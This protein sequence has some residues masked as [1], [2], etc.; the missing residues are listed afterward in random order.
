MEPEEQVRKIIEQ[1]LKAA[2]EAAAELESR[3]ETDFD[4][5]E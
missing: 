3:I 4:D 5:R 2:Q 1:A